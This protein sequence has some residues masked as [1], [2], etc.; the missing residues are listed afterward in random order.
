MGLKPQFDAITHSTVF[1]DNNGALGLANMPQITPWSK[2]FAVKLYF[3]RHHV[4]SGDIRIVRVDTDKQLA[5]T[6]TKALPPDQFEALRLSI[7]GW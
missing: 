2:H 7:Q 6:F 5:D 3:F 1:E 4:A